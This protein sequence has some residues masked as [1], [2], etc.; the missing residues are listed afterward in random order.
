MKKQT[1]IIEI[2]GVS[3]ADANRYAEGNRSGGSPLANFKQISN[4]PLTLH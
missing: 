2:G 1:Y 4:V 3:P